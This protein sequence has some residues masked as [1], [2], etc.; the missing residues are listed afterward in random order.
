MHPFFALSY[1]RSWETSE[2]NAEF[3]EEIENLVSKNQRAVGTS[4]EKSV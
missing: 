2:A 1:I 4:L 3:D